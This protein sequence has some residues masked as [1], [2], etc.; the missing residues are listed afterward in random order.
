MDNGKEKS[1]PILHRKIDVVFVDKKGEIVE[2][3]RF[4][5]KGCTIHDSGLKSFKGIYQTFDGMEKEFIRWGFTPEEFMS[6]MDI[7][8]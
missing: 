3:R 1:I 2:E 8:E 7:V 6:L 5:F 4:F